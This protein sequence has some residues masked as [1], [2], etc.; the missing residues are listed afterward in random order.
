[1][2]PSLA[3]VISC[4][5]AH[6]AL[7]AHG[8]AVI[9]STA[10][11]TVAASTLDATA[12]T[13]TLSG[14]VNAADLYA[15]GT[16][17]TSL[18]S[19]D[20]SGVVIAAYDSTTPL[21]GSCHYAAGTIPDMAF[22]GLPLTSLT[23]PSAATAIGDGAFAATSISTLTIPAGVTSVG[24]G[25]FQNCANLKSVTLGT[26]TYGVNAFYGCTALTTV[27][28]AGATTVSDGTFAGCTALTTVTGT[29][30]LTGIGAEAFKG[31][32]ALST[33]DFDSNLATIGNSAFEGT[34]LVNANLSECKKLAALG[35]RVFASCHSLTG[36]TLPENLTTTGT[37]VYFDC[38]ELVSVTLP[39]SLVTLGD[40]FTATDS[41]L[42]SL[43]IED[44]NVS[45]IGEYALMGNKAIT[46]VTLPESTTSLGDGAMEG[47][48][49]LTSIDVTHLDNAPTLGSEVFSGIEQSKVLLVVT[50]DNY[51][52]FEGAEQWKE[53]K[54]N[55]PSNSQNTISNDVAGGV[56]GRFVGMELQIESRGADLTT[57]QIYGLDGA[58]LFSSA[59]TGTIFAA[60]T[61]SIGGSLFIVSVTTADGQRMSLKTVR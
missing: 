36:S 41:K 54:I 15:I 43:N 16:H 60:D 45:T 17:M 27:N 3:I 4:I 48:T 30:T 22:M 56:Y 6:F 23:L 14:N 29:S 31:C 39:E 46:T 10:P 61:S 49:G 33:F 7:S 13:L 57:V 28:L 9:T 35:N 53:F 21:N 55:R 11:G 47:M 25:A 38:P 1:M 18:T 20:L 59:A 2:K 24:A 37:G 5:M 52:E 40:H 42:S 51:E 58:L 8:Q 12:T 26:A 44:T 50:T 34:A 19:L 32:S